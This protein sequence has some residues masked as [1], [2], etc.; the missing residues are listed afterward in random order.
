VCGCRLSGSASGDAPRL[1]ARSCAPWRIVVVAIGW[2]ALSEAAHAEKWTTSASVGATETYNHSSGA[3]QSG[4]DGF[5]TSLTAGAGISGEGARL[6]LR[7]NVSGTELFYAGQGQGDTFAPSVNLAANLEAIERF[8]F[9]DAFAV[10]TQT[11]ISPFGAQPSNLATPSNNRYTAQTYDISPYIQGVIAPNTSYSLRD[12]NIWTRS[13]TFGDSSAKPPGTYGN[14]LTGQMSSSVGLWSWSLDYNRQYYDNG[15]TGGASTLQ[16]ARGI[17]SYKVDPQVSLSL[18]GGYE[19]DK[20]SQAP[21]QQGSFYGAGLSWRPTERTSVDGFWEHHFYGSEYSAQLTH[22]LPNVALS[23]SASQGLS[24]FPQL[25]FQIPGGVPLAQLLDAAFRTRIPDPAERAQA[26]AQ[27]LAQSGLPPVLPSSLNFYTTQTTLQQTESLSAVWVGALNSIGFTV[28]R[29]KS[30]SIVGTLPGLPDALQFAANSTQTGCAVNFSH[31]LSG[32]TNL[33][34][35]VGYTRTAPNGGDD[36]GNNARTSNVNTFVGLST[37]FTPK[38]SGS[39]GLSY[40]VA[41]IAGTNGNSS[42]VSAY[43]SISHTF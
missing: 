28:F 20:F 40:F 23:A 33:V 19:Y 7:A 26:V 35:G 24:N 39:V 12:D 30:E 6:K 22:R 11:F 38:T 1:T 18:R 3:G 41:D 43:A 36:S 25:A 15:I 2:T 16:I 9:V 42:T 21:T 31:R 14:N 37:Q 13:S 27:F 10:V 29:T 32:F 8:F 4:G 34:A 5:V 17:V